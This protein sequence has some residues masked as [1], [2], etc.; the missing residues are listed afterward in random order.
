[1]SAFFLF[2]HGDPDLK[3]ELSYFFTFRQCLAFREEKKGLTILIY[4][5]PTLSLLPFLPLFRSQSYKRNF[6][7][8]KCK[9]V[10]N[11]LYRVCH[12][13]RLIKQDDYF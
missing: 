11:A 12:G 10:F 6:T 9:L 7:L 1:M 2:G 13:F 3:A 8:N 4:F 5:Q